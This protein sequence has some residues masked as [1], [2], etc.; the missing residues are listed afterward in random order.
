MSS[1]AW[2]LF[3]SDFGPIMVSIRIL[4]PS[5]TKNN[6]FLTLVCVVSIRHVYNSRT[7]SVSNT[8]AA[9]KKHMEA[10]PSYSFTSPPEKFICI[11][12]AIIFKKG[13]STA[14]PFYKS[15]LCIQGEHWNFEHFVPIKNFF[16]DR[17][18]VKN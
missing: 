2:C 13:P 6:T 14:L 5:M 17:T 8:M 9:D 12:I 18:I 11:Q 7:I 16:C 3:D 15:Y 1:M 4:V 10:G